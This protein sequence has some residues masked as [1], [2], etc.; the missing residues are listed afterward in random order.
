MRSR[1]RIVGLT[2]KAEPACASPR[3]GDPP[4]GMAGLPSSG[5]SV[6]ASDLPLLL[7]AD[8][9]PQGRAGF[10]L[11]ETGPQ[12]MPGRLPES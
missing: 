7:A 8:T 6:V 11:G 4:R 5:G 3:R 10:H 9:R 2:E 12:V 1:H